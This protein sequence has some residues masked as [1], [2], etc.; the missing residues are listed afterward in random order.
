[1][2]GERLGPNVVERMCLSPTLH[3]P[4]CLLTSKLGADKRSIVRES[5]LSHRGQLTWLQDLEM[6]FLTSATLVFS[7][8]CQV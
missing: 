8:A 2:E 1:M 7:V 6:A 5:G 3:G 4:D